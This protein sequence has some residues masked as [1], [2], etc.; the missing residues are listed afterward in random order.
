MIQ[1]GAKALAGE[2]E[3][4][5]AILFDAVDRER[6]I[7]CRGKSISIFDPN[8]EPQAE[9]YWQHH[10]NTNAEK[11]VPKGYEVRVIAAYVKFDETKSD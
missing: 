6:K 10:E 11:V 3:F 1:I 8:A 4:I 7:S 5:H 9:P 2:W